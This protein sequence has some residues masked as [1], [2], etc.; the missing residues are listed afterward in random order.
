MLVPAAGGDPVPG[1]TSP[2][3]S[4]WT[5]GDPLEFDTKYKY[6]FTIVDQAGRETKKA[7]TFTT[8]ATANEADAAVYPLQRHHGRRRTAHR[9][10]LQR[11]GR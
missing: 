4:T 6:S 8:V 3:G 1:T 7:Q 9:D 2:D 10:R 11:A 5:A